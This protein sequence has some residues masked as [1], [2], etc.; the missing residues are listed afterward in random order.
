ML[1]EEGLYVRFVN[2]VCTLRTMIQ[3]Q[4]FSMKHIQLFE[5]PLPKFKIIMAKHLPHPHFNITRADHT[6]L[7]RSHR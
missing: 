4:S 3:K 6:F 7:F 2:I 5:P 1:T